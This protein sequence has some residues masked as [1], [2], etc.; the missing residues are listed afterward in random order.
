MSLPFHASPEMWRSPAGRYMSCR[1]KDENDPFTLLKNLLTDGRAVYCVYFSGEQIRQ[2]IFHY[3]DPIVCYLNLPLN[4]SEKRMRD[5]GPRPCAAYVREPRVEILRGGRWDESR[6]VQPESGRSYREERRDQPTTG[7]RE[8]RESR[9][10]RPE[11]ARSQTTRSGAVS[12]A[13]IIGG[14]AAYG[15]T[16]P[17]GEPRRAS[18]TD[19]RSRSE[20]PQRCEF[21]QALRGDYRARQGCEG[22]GRDG[23]GG[24]IPEFAPAAEY[25]GNPFQLSG[26]R[27]MCLAGGRQ[28]HFM[29]ETI[30][31]RARDGDKITIYAY[32]FDHPLVIAR[33]VDAVHRGAI[34][35][36]YMDT[37]YLLGDQMSRH[38]TRLLA[39]ALEETARVQDRGRLRIYQVDG[40]NARPVYDRYQRSVSSS[41]VGSCHAKAMYCYPY[42]IMGSA[43]WSISSEANRELSAVFM[44]EDNDTRYYIEGQLAE[45][46]VGVVERFRS[47][48][49]RALETDAV[50]ATGG[51]STRSRARATG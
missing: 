14:D 38:G 32:S 36:V 44:V 15:M 6:S 16:E 40:R 13:R 25:A 19:T 51:P 35:Q 45:L 10:R 41:I 18:Q 9:D 39:N 11:P 5:F 1:R 7:Y 50:R 29:A 33:M 4:E 34:V 23:A 31:R 27:L 48:L 24:E 3:A 49:L 26:A 37:K 47:D 46:H 2:N 17:F 28:T 42:F 43:N 30:L 20:S 22:V 12:G 8:V 21:Y